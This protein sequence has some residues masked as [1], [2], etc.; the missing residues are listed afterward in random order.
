MV[1]SKD[2]FESLWQVVESET[3]CDIYS[4]FPCMNP[5][6]V[7][8]HSRYGWSAGIS[9]PL[10]SIPTFDAIL[11]HDLSNG[12]TVRRPLGAGCACG[13]ILFVPTPKDVSEGEDDGHILVMTH[14]VNEDRA[15]LLILDAQD[16]MKEPTAVVHIPVRV[17]FGFHCEYVPGPLAD[18]A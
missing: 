8:R 4:D 11:K 15:E 9:M 17:P 13:D 12:Q 1:E 16:I 6:Y 7:G 2:D 5:N 18:W 14:I 3:V 10:T